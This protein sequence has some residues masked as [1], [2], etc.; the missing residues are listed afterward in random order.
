MDTGVPGP[1]WRGGTSWPLSQCDKHSGGLGVAS[2]CRFQQAPWSSSPTALPEKKMISFHSLCA[3]FLG[4]S[5]ELEERDKGGC[6]LCPPTQILNPVIFLGMDEKLRRKSKSTDRMEMEIWEPSEQVARA[7]L[8]SPLGSWLCEN[9]KV[10]HSQN[11][12]LA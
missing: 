7:L 5:P 3:W 12:R 2:V 8:P 11:L 10:P 9:T 1:P 6:A 4:P